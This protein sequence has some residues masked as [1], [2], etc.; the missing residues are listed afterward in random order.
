[1]NLNDLIQ[2]LVSNPENPLII[3]SSFISRP[4]GDLQ[5]ENFNQS[6]FE[7]KEGKEEI[8][9]LHA[10][11]NGFPMT[12][13]TLAYILECAQNINLIKKLYLSEHN[14][15]TTKFRNCKL[16]KRNIN[17]DLEERRNINVN[18]ER[19][20]RDD[21]NEG[22]TLLHQQ[23]QVHFPTAFNRVK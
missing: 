6:L 21:I 14:V 3:S 5:L 7:S 12:G 1:M 4:I 19:K 13:F 9:I 16:I 18:K 17:R 8:I 2:F 11:F 10:V 23:L 22:F 15:A 20:R